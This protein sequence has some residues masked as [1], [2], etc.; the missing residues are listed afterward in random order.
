MGAPRTVFSFESFIRHAILIS[1]GLNV[2]SLSFHD[3]VN[4][5]ICRESERY[6]YEGASG[7]EGPYRERE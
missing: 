7:S 4:G 5:L 6:V 2:Y 3:Y 1:L